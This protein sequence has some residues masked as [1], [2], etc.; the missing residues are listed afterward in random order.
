MNG[1]ALILITIL[2][3]FIFS[4]IYLAKEMEG[5]NKIEKTKHGNYE[6]FIRGY[7]F[8]HSLGV[9]ET[10]AEAMKEIRDFYE[11]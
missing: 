2:L 11:N 1:E 5:A 8:Y 6:A 3:L 7:D 9:F 4:M 10:K